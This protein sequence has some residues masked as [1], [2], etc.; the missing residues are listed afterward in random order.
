MNLK[1]FQSSLDW[2]D[3]SFTIATLKEQVAYLLS[4]DSMYSKFVEEKDEN[5]DSPTPKPQNL[6]ESNLSPKQIIKNVYEEVENS[7]EDSEENEEMKAGVNQ[8]PYTNFDQFK[9]EVMR[10]P[11]QVPNPKTKSSPKLR[12]SRRAKIEERKSAYMYEDPI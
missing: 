8:T 12:K 3:I 9:N 4:R 7:V 2:V 6:Q 1:D 5:S 11:Y 10:N